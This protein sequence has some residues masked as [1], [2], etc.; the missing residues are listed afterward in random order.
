LRALELVL[1]LPLRLLRLVLFAATARP[2]L[3]PFRHVVSAAVLY[4]LFA[5]LLVY[6]VAPLRG[7]VGQRFLGEK[8][9]YDAE[10]WLATAVYDAGGGFVGTFDPR[11][12][13]QRDVNY[14]DAAIRIG[15]YIANPDH[16]SIPVREVPEHYWRCLV[17]HE[18][19]ISAGCSTPTASTS[20]ASS[21]SRSPPSG[22]RS[23]C[24]SPA[25]ASAARRCPCSSCA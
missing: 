21:R 13:S 11:L 4:L 1:A 9:R 8:L 20:S 25:S 12:D 22:G 23:R 16:K 18:T 24:G 7:I 6:A 17:H 19:A 10:R 5:V 15:S 3:G 2:N 14:T